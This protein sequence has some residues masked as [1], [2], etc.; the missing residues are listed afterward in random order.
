MR[1]RETRK[2]ASPLSSVRP[3]TFLE[4][5]ALKFVLE[6]RVVSN[7]QKLPAHLLLG[8]E[9]PADVRLKF[10]TCSAK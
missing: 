6:H 8:K 4:N 2:S 9:M 3:N 10:R 1:L 7:W 5:I